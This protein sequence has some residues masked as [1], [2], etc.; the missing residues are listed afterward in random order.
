MYQVLFEEPY[1]QEDIK[2]IR[3]LLLGSLHPSIGKKDHEQ[4]NK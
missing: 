1:E 3:S 4:V 2:K